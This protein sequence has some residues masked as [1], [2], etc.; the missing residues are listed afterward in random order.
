[1]SV[2]M[3][4]RAPR[5]LYCTDSY[6]PR[7][8]GVSVVTAYHAGLEA[9]A[10]SLAARCLRPVVA[11]YLAHFHGRAA[12]T[13]V[14]CG[15]ARA[16]LLALGQRNVELWGPSV[17][18]K[19]FAPKHRRGGLRVAL[20]LEYRFVFLYVGRLV[21]EKGVD[22][23]LEAFRIARDMLPARSVHLIVAG[24]GPKASALRRSAPGDVTFLGVLDRAKAL[25]EL[26]ASADAFLSASHT[27]RLGLTML[28]AMASGLPV[29]AT[30][31]RA[32][33]DHL[34]D[35]AN[36][37]AVPAGAVGPMAH[38]MLRLVMHPRLRARL[39]AGARL[40]A[41]AHPPGAALD[42]LEQSYRDV[43]AIRARPAAFAG[44]APRS[45]IVPAG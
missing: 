12:R 43:C 22:R 25:P 30:A 40:T 34:R 8:H 37:L 20:G 31:A 28:E 44:C 21:A 10:E 17:D 16:E 2:A 6:P 5:V 38:A 3:S 11:R 27:E 23:V 9:G 19:A 42:Q 15:A 45:A 36:G 26:Y 24:V 7:V 29:I 18:G 33:A 41:E 1:M 4:G 14:P 32:A 35:D 13:L 39:A